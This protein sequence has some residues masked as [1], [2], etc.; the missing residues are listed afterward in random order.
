MALA[1]VQKM[2]GGAARPR[3]TQMAEAA[4]AARAYLEV[5]LQM[6]ADLPEGEP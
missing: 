4:P 6:L 1:R 2:Q 3:M 5:V